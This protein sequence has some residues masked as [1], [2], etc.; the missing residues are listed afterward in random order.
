LDFTIF[1]QGTL[2]RSGT[3]EVIIRRNFFLTANA[4]NDIIGNCPITMVGSG[5]IRTTNTFDASRGSRL[6]LNIN[7]YGRIFI[8]SYYLAGTSSGGTINFI[9]GRLL[10]GGVLYVRNTGVITGAGKANFPN[11]VID[12]GATIYMNEFFSGTPERTSI[13]TSSNTTNYTI[14]IY[15]FGEKIAK[16]VKVSNCTSAIRGQVLILTKGANGGSNL[17]IRYYNQSPNG[18]SRKTIFIDDNYSSVP[19]E[20]QHPMLV[21]DPTIVGIL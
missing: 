13:I 5:T 9:R 6:T 20:M 4:A 21:A 17:G 16:F 7:T 11:V 18:V 19:L 1:G 3:G 8:E 14:E 10:N 15:T 2:N 12:G